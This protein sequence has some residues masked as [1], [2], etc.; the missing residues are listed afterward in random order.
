M[1]NTLS[2]CSDPKAPINDLPSGQ[3]Q[4][5]NKINFNTAFNS[6]G[7]PLNAFQIA[8]KNAK[9]LSHKFSFEDSRTPIIEKDIQ[10]PVMEHQYD[11]DIGSDIGDDVNGDLNIKP[12]DKNLNFDAE[13][14]Q[15][16]KQNQQSKILQET[17]V[18]EQNFYLSLINSSKIDDLFDDVIENIRNSLDEGILLIDEEYCKDSNGDPLA[19][20]VFGRDVYFDEERHHEIVQ[21]WRMELR[22]EDYMYFNLFMNQD[23]RNKI[24]SQIDSFE[25]MHIL[26]KDGIVYYWTKLRTKKVLMLKGKETLIMCAFKELEDGN[27]M[28]VYKSWEHPDYP[29]M[30]DLPRVNIH[31]GGILFKKD[32][33]SDGEVMWDCTNYRFVNPQVSVGVKLLKPILNKYYKGLFLYGFRELEKFMNDT[34]QDDWNNYIQIMKNKFEP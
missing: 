12:Y 5:Q 4:N 17:K 34:T 24:D 13:I 21:K 23:I 27:F 32:I 16:Q 6:V 14:F 1:G 33:N 15:R 31:K 10:F 9:A 28:E 22:P 29:I 2:C 19:I 30:D 20:K 3:W 25:L 26:Y 8:E 11:D 7:Q 18:N